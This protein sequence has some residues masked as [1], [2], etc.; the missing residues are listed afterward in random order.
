MVA[1]KATKL[2]QRKKQKICADSPTHFISFVL[3]LLGV[4]YR[5]T[6]KKKKNE[7]SI[8]LS[9]FCTEDYSRHVRQREFFTSKRLLFYAT[10]RLFLLFSH[11]AHQVEFESLSA[12]IF[13]LL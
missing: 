13:S 8:L 2:K 4:E 6:M 12:H 1:L 10:F 11:L 3:R 9:P 7:L 5:R